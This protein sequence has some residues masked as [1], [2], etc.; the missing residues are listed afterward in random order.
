MH[1]VSMCLYIIIE[2]N[3]DGELFLTLPD[4]PD[5]MKDLELSPGGKAKIRGIIKVS[6]LSYKGSYYK[7]YILF[8]LM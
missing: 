7:L 5:L 6:T 1:V 8:V 2:G 3:V 4:D